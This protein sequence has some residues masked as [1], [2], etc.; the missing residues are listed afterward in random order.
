MLIRRERQGY[1]QILLLEP[2]R[3]AIS[4]VSNSTFWDS[5]IAPVPKWHVVVVRTRCAYPLAQAGDVFCRDHTGSTWLREEREY[6]VSVRI[7]LPWAEQWGR[8]KLL[9]CGAMEG[10]RS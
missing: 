4:I 10:S 6:V 9:F 8:R 5:A 2:V 1:I 3:E 7:Q